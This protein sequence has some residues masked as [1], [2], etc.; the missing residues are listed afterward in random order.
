MIELKKRLV[1]GMCVA[2][3]LFAAVGCGKNGE[4]TK[5]TT[6][7][8]TEEQSDATTDSSYNPV[9][10]KKDLDSGWS[11]ET[12]VQIQLS[13]EGSKIVGEG[14]VSLEGGIK[15]S[16]GGVYAISGKLTD[17]RIIV[18]VEPGEELKLVLD[19]VDI[20][21]SVSAPL[22]VSN[23]D[24]IIILA[25]NTENVLTDSDA[26]QYA[27]N[28]VKEPNACLY[29]DDNITIIGTG[30]LT[31]NSN[32]NNGIGTKDE[33]RIASGTIVVHAVNNAFKGNDCILI[34]DAD[35]HIESKGDGMKSD[36]DTLEGHG[37]ISIINSNIEIFADDDGIQAVNRIS[38]EGGQIAVTAKG[39]KINCDATIDIEEGVL[40]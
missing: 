17:G 9:F 31:V 11:K 3:I 32:F 22:Y 27:D 6:S 16:E 39:K 5:K 12:A 2:F 1:G 10:E 24:A 18:D 7:V 21:S 33:L 29:G 8:P 37:V 26:Y 23:G 20:T 40:R 28:A 13:D 30:K 19:G 14:A 35:I 38:A 34:Q 4:D 25:E 15:I 36:E